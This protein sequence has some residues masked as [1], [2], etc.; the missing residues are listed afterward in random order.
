VSAALGFAAGED[1]PA[2]ERRDPVDL[3]KVRETAWAV[4][5]AVLYLAGVVVGTAAT[6][7][8]FDLWVGCAWLVVGGGIPAYLSM[9]WPHQRIAARE[10]R[11]DQE[12][13]RNPSGPVLPPG[14]AA[15]VERRP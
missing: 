7:V 10:L 8:A 11:E 3:D 5:G 14:P 4:A 15:V 13:F 12:R 6:T 2:P 1:R 9:R